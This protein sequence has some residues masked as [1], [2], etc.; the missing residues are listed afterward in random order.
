MGLHI[1]W[2]H[3]AGYGAVRLAGAPSLG[4]FYSCIE[5]LSVESAG[6]PHRRLLVDLRGVTTLHSFTEQFAIGEEAARRLG[7][8]RKIASVVPEGRRTRNSERPARRQGLNLLVFTSEEEAVAWLCS[9][10]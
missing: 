9:D 2:E 6:W 8:L 7:H 4:Q 5:L 10:D 3:H 1:D